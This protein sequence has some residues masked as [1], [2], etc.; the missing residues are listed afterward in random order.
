MTTNIVFSNFIE[1]AT[2]TVNLGVADILWTLGENI[3]D[4]E[5]EA[6]TSQGIAEDIF[7]L[8]FDIENLPQIA[9]ANQVDHLVRGLA[10]YIN[11]NEFNI[12]SIQGAINEIWEVA[13]G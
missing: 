1:P 7:D 6:L 5:I 4:R 2:S 3:V 10:T 9:S 11:G 8:A 12:Q 13:T